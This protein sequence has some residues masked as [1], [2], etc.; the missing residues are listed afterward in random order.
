MSLDIYLYKPEISFHECVCESCG[1]KHESL[2]RK[3]FSHFNLTH[4]L[5]K[6]ASE[7][8]IYNCL[9]RPEE[10]G[11]EITNQ[12]I[13]LLRK[14]LHIL[15]D[16]AERFEAYNPPNK[17]GSYEHLVEVVTDYLK[18]CEKNPEATIQVSR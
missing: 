12:M 18:A 2:E 10:N 16:D 14:G 3:W 11:I 5:A 17:Y 1:N 9:W 13:P 8:G 4:N 15:I 7:A 6:M